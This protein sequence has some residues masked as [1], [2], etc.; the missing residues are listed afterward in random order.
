MLRAERKEEWRKM[1][2]MVWMVL[3]IVVLIAAG[4]GGVVAG[5]VMVLK[6]AEVADIDLSTVQDGAYEGTHKYLGITNRV[7][8]EVRGHRIVAI[9][10]N[11]NR[12]SDYLDRAKGVAKRVI[13]KQSLN[14]DTVTGATV[15][16]KAVLK[17]VE[18]AL[19]RGKR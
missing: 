13:G 5:G 9:E 17:A 4:I 14:V 10:V 1:R 3:G 11:E 19:E 8:V 12:D 2:K 6:R 18:N 16:S 7:K 15:S